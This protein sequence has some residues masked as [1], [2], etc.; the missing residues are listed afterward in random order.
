MGRATRSELDRF[1]SKVEI[2]VGCWRWTGATMAN[3]YGVFTVTSTALGRRSNILAHRW[4]YEHI[5]G[6][7]PAGLEIDH[8]CRTRNCVRID[9]LEAV[10]HGEN[11]RRMAQAQTHCRRAGHEYT[12]ENT[13]ISSKGARFCRE[14]HRESDRRRRAANDTDLD[15]RQPRGDIA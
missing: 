6:A 14:C 15:N 7:I 13:L 1:W 8:L 12:P 10:T 3:G 2:S 9:H 4:A 5:H 11:Q